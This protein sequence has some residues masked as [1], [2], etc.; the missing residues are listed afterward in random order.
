MLAAAGAA[1]IPVVALAVLA[2]VEQVALLGELLEQQI[3]GA[4]VAEL[5]IKPLLALV[6]PASSS[7]VMFISEVR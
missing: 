1:A 6:V 2:A 3:Q 4:A 7:F 5:I